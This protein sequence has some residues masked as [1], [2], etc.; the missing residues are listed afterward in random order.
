MNVKIHS[1]WGIEKLLSIHS[2]YFVYFYVY[3]NRDW[4]GRLAPM[5][6]R[7]IAAARA[8]MEE[9]GE[10]EGGGAVAQ[11]LKWAFPIL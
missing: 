2:L 3:T 7:A 5:S 8:E 11:Q 1:E 6:S 4:K 10:E 9:E